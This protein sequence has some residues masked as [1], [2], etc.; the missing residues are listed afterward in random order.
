MRFIYRKLHP[1]RANSARVIMIFPH[2]VIKNGGHLGFLNFFE[3]FFAHVTFVIYTVYLSKTASKSN[4]Q[5]SS[6][7]GTDRQTDILYPFINSRDYRLYLTKHMEIDRTLWM[8]DSKINTL[9]SPCS[10]CLFVVYCCCFFLKQ[11][12]GIFVVIL[13]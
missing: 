5:F 8:A 12:P 1:N 11:N 9:P 4:Q 3:N 10:Y 13:I 6:Y 2:F 7:R